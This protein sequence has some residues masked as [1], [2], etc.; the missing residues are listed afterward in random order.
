MET[1]AAAKWQTPRVSLLFVC[2]FH[3]CMRA[4]ECTCMNA[5][6]C[7][8]VYLLSRS[9]CGPGAWYPRWLHWCQDKGGYCLPTS[10]TW[11]WPPPPPPP[12]APCAS[13]GGPE[14]KYVPLR[15]LARRSGDGWKKNLLPRLEWPHSLR[16]QKDGEKELT[17]HKTT[18]CGWLWLILVQPR[19]QWLR[20]TIRQSAPL[21]E[22][23][24]KKSITQDRTIKRF[25]FYP[26]SANWPP[27]CHT[28]RPKM[29]QRYVHS[30][31]D[32]A[33]R[34]RMTL[35]WSWDGLRLSPSMGGWNLWIT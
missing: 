18:H 19:A 17:R 4:R 5:N 31:M 34:R 11:L 27:V 21:F 32:R 26:S 3:A 2:V 16:P 13:S 1:G 24:K 12:L 33:V 20:H 10:A 35:L 29:S 23:K 8:R 9:V 22:K 25:R 28:N 6:V 14:P 30:V 15:S 7:M